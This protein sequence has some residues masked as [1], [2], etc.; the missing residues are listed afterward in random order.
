M[1]HFDYLKPG[2][3]LDLP[4]VATHLNVSNPEFEILASTPGGMGVCI[5]LKC[6]SNL[7]T[8]ALKCIYP[9]LIGD[10][11]SMNRF[12][13]ELDVWISASACNAVAEA[14]AI[15]QVN[16][17]PTVLATWMDGGDLTHALP[18][19]NLAQKFETIVRILRALQWGP[20]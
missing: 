2:S 13:D 14:I 6:L 12:H 10:K 5:Q 16:H 9:E 15:V 1:L 19:L 17:V 3:Q 11:E 20:Y 8:Y 18:K 7:E 4:E